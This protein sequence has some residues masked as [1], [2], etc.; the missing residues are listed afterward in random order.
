MTKA[1]MKAA[2]SRSLYLVVTR[3]PPMM[4]AALLANVNCVCVSVHACMC[5]RA[6]MCVCSDTPFKP[7]II[8]NTFC[9]KKFWSRGNCILRGGLAK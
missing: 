4:V 6:C 5:M 7:C 9:K 1:L 8:I 2:G 3:Q